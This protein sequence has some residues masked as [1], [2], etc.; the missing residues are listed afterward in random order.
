MKPLDKMAQQNPSLS[1]LPSG[2]D[3]MHLTIQE[4][5]E[6]VVTLP[7]SA[8]SVDPSY[9]GSAAGNFPSSAS[10]NPATAFW[11]DS[12]SDNFIDDRDDFQDASDNF[13]DV[14]DN[15]IDGSDNFIDASDNMTTD[16]STETQ[17]QNPSP[18]PLVS[19]SDDMPLTIQGPVDT[20]VPL[21]G[22]PLSVASSPAGSMIDLTSPTRGAVSKPP[23]FI[24]L[25]QDEEL[26]RRI[27]DEWNSPADVE[28]E[29]KAQEERDAEYARMLSMQWADEKF[30]PPPPRAPVSVN[31]P[32]SASSSSA[33]SI[34]H[35]N[36][37]VGHQEL[38]RKRKQEE[39]DERLAKR[40]QAEMNALTSKPKSPSKGAPPATS[41][42]Q[43]IAPAPLAAS[44]F[45]AST[46]FQAKGPVPPA[47]STSMAFPLFQTKGPAAST[48]QASSPFQTKGPAPLA[49]STSQAS[50]SSQTKA[51]YPPFK[52]AAEQRKIKSPVKQASILSTKAS[53]FATPVK[54]DQTAFGQLKNKKNKEET[55]IYN[56]TTGDWKTPVVVPE[57]VKKPTGSRPLPT[58]WSHDALIQNSGL[59]KH[60][61]ISSAKT[62]P[63]ATPVKAE[64]SLFGDIMK[65]TPKQATPVFDLTKSE[66]RSPTVVPDDKKK[67]TGMGSLPLPTSWSHDALIQNSGLIK[68]SPRTNLFGTPEQTLF[69]TST[70]PIMNLTRGDWRPVVIPDDVKKPTGSRPLPTSWSHD[71]LIQ[72]SGLI[73]KTATPALSFHEWQNRAQASGSNSGIVA[74]TERD[75]EGDVI[76]RDAFNPGIN[77][78]A[79]MNAI[80][81]EPYE[82]PQYARRM[83]QE[84]QEE[85]LKAMFDAIEA[86]EAPPPPEQRMETPQGL[87]I[88]LMEHQKIGVEWLTQREEKGKG[89]LLADDMGLGKTVQSIALIVARPPPPPRPN[90]D[91]V[92]QKRCT[93]IVAP[94]ALAHQ[95]YHEI[96]RKTTPGKFKIVIYHGQNRDKNASRLAEHDIIITT[97]SIVGM[98][99]PAREKKG[100][101]RG[102]EAEQRPFGPLFEITY[103]RIILDEAQII[104]NKTTQAAIACCALKAEFRWCL[105]GTPIQNSLDELYSL[106][107]FL[108]IP[109]YC[110]WLKFK[111]DIIDVVKS[112]HH[113]RGYRRLQ[114]LMKAMCLRRTKDATIDGRKVLELPPRNVTTV[115]ATFTPEEREFYSAL[116][117]QAR[118][119][120]NK[121]LLAGT[122]MKNYSS[123]L[124][125]LLRLRQACGHPH[126]LSH[127]F[128]QD[129]GPV[130]A[131]DGAAPDPPAGPEKVAETEDDLVAGLSVE[132]VKRLKNQ[133]AEG[134]LERECGICMDGGDSPML[135]PGCGHG[136]FCKECLTVYAA[137]GNEDE[138]GK[139]CPSC[140]GPL[141]VDRLVPLKAFIRIHRP[142]TAAIEGKGKAPAT[143]EDDATA[144]AKEIED[145]S[146][147]VI[148]AQ[149]ANYD[150]DEWISSTK[151]DRMMYL[152]RE[153]RK[154]H[155]GE[156]TVIFSQFTKL[157]DLIEYPLNNEKEKFKYVRYDGTMTMRERAE[158]ISQFEDEEGMEVALI[159]LKC[160]SLGLNLTCANRVI[161]M[162]L[163]WNQALENQAIDRCHRIGQLKAVEVS[164]IVIPDTVEDRIL[165]LQDQKRD[166]IE[167][168]LGEGQA[169]RVGRLGLEDL[170]FLFGAPA[171]GV[172]I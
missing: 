69:G 31:A 100:K 160:G 56:L 63:I 34:P 144:A 153:T 5:V 161:I 110:D 113:K 9:I 84:Q 93:L 95:W 111:S 13:I 172:A 166:I 11:D 37:A 30:T 45:Q 77:L 102:R 132:V 8:V 44:P 99:H 103:H 16:T 171:P 159:S 2:F 150:T 162:D 35:T 39:E 75:F 79:Q 70:T 94:V 20:T 135:I 87:T 25:T 123:I 64:P 157:L 147:L 83:T 134:D 118:I 4:P 88:Q 27:S 40:M 19:H 169:E 86:V 10:S 60:S 148:P 23:I 152:L 97:Y 133:D 116:E 124:V 145:N 61:P 141:P 74:K 78:E 108:R 155:P 112:S 154:N 91:P 117:Q 47:A 46:S 101:D 58:S 62:N 92:D 142:A 7:G 14:S 128:V 96:T 33:P 167:G 125:L 21:P 59:V 80:L 143:A 151:I 42:N 52:T 131:I 127:D 129:T 17:Q 51:V 6:N 114:V 71:A 170:R 120:F 43:K 106:I 55:E 29:R 115:T 82:P 158:V 107:K 65:K 73:N 67:A 163:W 164:R 130:A 140:R 1:P 85:E 89:G 68:Q 72:N 53:P 32:S 137:G 146:A 66:W 41:S 28:R 38:E 119:R 149:P 22:S 36:N 57:S 105:S 104:K 165:K 54:A 48:L 49:A 18:T 90:T 139:P 121:F 98:E 136:P 156:K 26:A 138:G 50:S 126:L 109:P 81:G 3:H 168:A 15:F 12:F 122:V 76:M 24:D